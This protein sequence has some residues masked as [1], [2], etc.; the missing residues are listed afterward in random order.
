M[1]DVTDLR[2]LARRA[3]DAAVGLTS[4]AARLTGIVVL[5]SVLVSLGSYA[6]GLAALSGGARDAWAVLGGIFAAI[7]L[8]AGFL[9]TWRLTS[10]RRH[11]S[12]LVDELVTL[13]E[14]DP[15]TQPVVIET[16]EV[17]RELPPAGGTPADPSGRAVVVTSRGYGPFGT[18]VRRSAADVPQLARSVRAV[19]TF[20]L[21][22]AVTVGITFVFALLVPFFLLALVL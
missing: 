9:A 12:S 3:V 1:A 4:R 5:V 20:P 22:L 11:A 21:L 14:R 2:V 7:A 17:G 8:G 18:V 6:L 10:V 19:T 16:F 13:M 15:S